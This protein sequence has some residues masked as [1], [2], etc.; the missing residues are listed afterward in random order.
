MFKGLFMTLCAVSTLALPAYAQS[1]GIT[2]E[3]KSFTFVLNG[4]AVTIER[5]GAACPPA[6]LQPMQAAPGVGTIGELEVLSFL[7][8]FVSQGRGL[9]VD[10]RLPNGYAAGTVPGAVNVPAATLR[11]NNPY[12][13][14]LLSALG[15]RSGDFSGAYSLV[16]FGNGPDDADAAEAV[17][18]L[19][20]SGYPASKLKFYRGGVQIWKALGLTLA[21]GR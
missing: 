11:P 19:I 16:I 15:V 7:D 17:K 8:V 1:S 9:L 21:S 12:Q 13:E 6:C 2:A 14:D 18:S 20:A 4:A 5:N 10:T 3:Q